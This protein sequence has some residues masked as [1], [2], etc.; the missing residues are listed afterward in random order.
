MEQVR[1]K[2]EQ[3]EARTV[4]LG[5]VTHEKQESREMEVQSIGGRTGAQE[6]SQREQT[7]VCKILNKVV[8]TSHIKFY[9]E[10]WVCI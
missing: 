9:L 5:L 10:F 4:G 7:N 8:F 6:S 1:A 3:R 2:R